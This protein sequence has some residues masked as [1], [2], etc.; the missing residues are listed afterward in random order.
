MPN[1]IFVIILLNFS[2]VVLSDFDLS[3][4]R[5]ALRT[6]WTLQTLMLIFTATGDIVPQVTEC[7]NLVDHIVINHQFTPNMIWATECY[8]FP[9]T[10]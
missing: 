6:F 4:L 5:M 7:V 2:S 8:S 10:M 1:R 3:V 9:F